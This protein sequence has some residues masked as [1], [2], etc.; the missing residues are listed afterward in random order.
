MHTE[1]AHTSYLSHC[2]FSC[3]C[4]V[5]IAVV[6]SESHGTWL[7]IP[8]LWETLFCLMFCRVRNLG[9]TIDV[10]SRF[11][12][13]DTS[14]RSDQEFD[15]KYCNVILLPKLFNYVCIK[16]YYV[17]AHICFRANLWPW[18]VKYKDTYKIYMLNQSPKGLNS[19]NLDSKFK[20][21]T[22]TEKVIK[23]H[24]HCA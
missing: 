20:H 9:E 17:T 12:E 7:W 5:D 24:F 2:K 4:R 22:F 21:S 15:K 1:N 19:Q 16:F 18:L 6:K 10:W 11:S 14:E 8:T 23:I 13:S 3:S